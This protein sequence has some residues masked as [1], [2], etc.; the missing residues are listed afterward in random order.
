M[1]HRFEGGRTLEDLIPLIKLLE[2]EGVDAFDID[3][4][5]YETLDYIFPPSYLGE[6]CMSYVTDAARKAVSVPLLNAGTHN[7][8]SAVELIQSGTADFAMIGRGLI[9]DPDLPNK[10]LAGN[11]E[12]IRPCLRCNENCIGRIWNNHTKLGCSVNIQAMEERRFKLETAEQAKKL[13]LSVVGLLVWKLLESLSF[14][15]MM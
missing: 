4:G 6:S 14:G 2:E 5:C 9:A 7:P 12:D 8:E 11:R 3:A 1:D 13:W 10:L 15:G